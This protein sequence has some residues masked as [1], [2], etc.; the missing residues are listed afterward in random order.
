MAAV[1]ALELESRM[2]QEG[3]YDALVGMRQQVAITTEC[4]YESLHNSVDSILDEPN[5][6]LIP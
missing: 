4:T 1:E 5:E 6:K 3:L 2:N